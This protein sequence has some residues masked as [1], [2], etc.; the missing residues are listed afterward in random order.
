MICIGKFSREQISS[1]EAISN[2]IVFVDSSPNEE[3]FDSVVIDFDSS[4]TEVLASMIK[5]GYTKIGYIG[6]I[7]HINTSVALGEKRESVFRE[8][9]TQNNLLEPK[10]IHIGT[11][12]SKS[13]YNLMKT[14]L[15]SKDIA[16]VYFCA[17]DSI[18]LGVLRAIHEKG[19]KVPEEI[20][21]VGF[22]N[23][24]TSKY[25]FP[26]L[27]TVHVYTEFMG[28]QALNSI[29]EKVE[30]RIIPLKKT[31]PTKLIHR[32]TLK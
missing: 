15:S 11:F 19:L 21:V 8:F 17:N 9:L 10:F 13:G 4:V 7:E 18:A 12:S 27:S 5:K 29:I 1:F 31:I 26:P 24:N 30:G 16:E 32:A 3:V 20:G 2:N 14:A 28:E 6:G 25:T 23:N 22:N